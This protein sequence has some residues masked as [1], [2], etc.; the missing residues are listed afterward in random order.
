M[1]N[2]KVSL[3]ALVFLIGVVLLPSIGFHKSAFAEEKQ[4]YVDLDGDGFGDNATDEDNDGIPDEA[5]SDF[6]NVAANSPGDGSMVNFGASLSVPNVENDL[7]PHSQQF[8]GRKFAARAVTQN[9]CGFTSEENFG[10]GNGIG[11][12]NTGGSGGCVGGVCH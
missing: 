10:S 9:R 7:A 2:P 6:K 5:D 4:I 12:T 1:R 11:I 8:D 3:M